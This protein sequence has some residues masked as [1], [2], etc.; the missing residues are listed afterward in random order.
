MCGADHEIARID[1]FLDI[2]AQLV[3]S[4]LPETPRLRDRISSLDRPLL[5]R[6]VGEINQF[7][8]RGEQLEGRFDLAGIERGDGA[9]GN[10]DVAG[11]RCPQILLRSRTFLPMT[12]RWISEVPSP[13]KSSGASR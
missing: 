11:R 4:S 13:I 2:G 8:I 12:I 5:V 3:E 6:G 9:L 7:G 1:V 10:F